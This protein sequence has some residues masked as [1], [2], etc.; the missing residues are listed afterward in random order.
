MWPYRSCLFH[1]VL[2]R[3]DHDHRFNGFFVEAFSTQSLFQDIPGYPINKK[4]QCKKKK[5]QGNHSSQKRGGGGPAR[6]N[7]DHIFNGF[8]YPFPKRSLETGI[9]VNLCLLSRP[10]QSQRLLYTHG[11][12]SF[13][14]SLTLFLQC[15]Q[16]A[17][18]SPNSW[19]RF[20][21]S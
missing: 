9:I 15:L 14:R 10:G 5:T 11:H 21:Q 4:K 18:P 8:F 16:L 3:Y 1:L 13:Y 6:Y 7:H 17:P 19:R 20:F 12:H 2:A